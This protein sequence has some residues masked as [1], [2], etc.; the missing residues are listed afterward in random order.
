MARA[1]ETLWLGDLSGLAVTR[2]GHGVECEH[3][4]VIEAGHPLPDDAAAAQLV[5]F[6]PWRTALEKMIFCCF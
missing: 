3:I 1:V 4:E 2:Y 6:S 5:G